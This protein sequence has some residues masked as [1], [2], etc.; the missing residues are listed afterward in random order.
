MIVLITFLFTYCYIAYRIP[1]RYHHRPSSS[2]DTIQ[3][4][5]CRTPQLRRCQICP[6]I[7]HTA[8]R[9]PAVASG[10][11]AAHNEDRDP[12][13]YAGGEFDG[14]EQADVL[15]AARALT[16]VHRIQN[17]AICTS[18]LAGWTLARSLHIS[19]VLVYYYYYE[20]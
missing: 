14:D 5:R 16:M 2:K 9:A 1:Q 19:I 13:E 11:G 8:R 15:R 3:P 7:L 20:N 4:Q 18:C 10:A 17:Q 6:P 12:L